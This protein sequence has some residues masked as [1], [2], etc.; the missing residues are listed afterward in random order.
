[1]RVNSH[2]SLV[3]PSSGTFRERMERAK[4]RHKQSSKRKLKTSMHD[5]DGEGDAPLPQDVRELWRLVKSK[6]VCREPHNA[7]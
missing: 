3:G 1:M 6:G 4:P 2:N 7:L 5:S